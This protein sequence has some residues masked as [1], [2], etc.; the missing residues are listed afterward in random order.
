MSV[1]QSASNIYIDFEGALVNTDIFV[2]NKLYETLSNHMD[3]VNTHPIH[4]IFEFINQMNKDDLIYFTKIKKTQNI[5]R[6]WAD[7]TKINNIPD[8]DIEEQLDYIC[9][10]I[11]DKIL[12][13]PYNPEVSDEFIFT[14]I[15]NSL[16]V[17]MKDKKMNKIYVY[18]K[19]LTEAIH[20]A[21][22]QTFNFFDKVQILTGDRRT[23]FSE[24]VCDT[25]IFNNIMDVELLPSIVEGVTRPKSDILF[26]SS[27]PNMDLWLN[28]FIDGDNTHTTVKE[29]YNAN[30]HI[31]S[32]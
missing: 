7:P 30:F 22:Y 12:Y 29:K 11:Y 31:L 3:I 4:P 21:I 9:D 27:I 2:C 5:L 25:Y 8:M 24:V 14:D 6:E 18:V 26:L 32:V 28:Y 16:S 1:L 17:L 20:A 23:F 10:D 13:H 15:A 19:D